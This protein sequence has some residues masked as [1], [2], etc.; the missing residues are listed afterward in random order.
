MKNV[1]LG[2]VVMVLCSG[3]AAWLPAGSLL[4]AQKKAA[5]GIRVSVDSRVELMSIIFRL[6]GNREYGQGK[7]PSYTQDVESHFGRFRD[8]AVVK[9]ATKL[10]QTRGVSYDAVMGMAVHVT[11]ALTLQEKVP[12]SPQPETLDPRWT[13]ESAREFLTLARQFVADTQFQDFFDKHEPLYRVAVQ[14]MQEVLDKHAHLDWFDRFFGP[15]QGADFHVVLGMLNGGSSY[16]ARVTGADGQEELYSVIGVWM[17]DSGGQPTFAPA[18]ASTVVHEFTHSYTNPLVDQFATQLQGP[19]EKLYGLVKKEM[20]GQAYGN[21]KTLMYESL[22]RAC[23][24]RYALA[25]G[26]PAAM[27]RAAAYESSRSFYWVGELADV[28]GEYD[29]QP[30]KYKDLAEFFPRITAFFE[31]YARNADAKIGAIKGKNQEQ[32]QQWRDKGPK[33]VSMVPANGAENVDPSLKAIVVTFDRPM[34]D[35]CWSVVTLGSQDEFPKGAGPVHYDAAR[36]VFTMP[37]A[38]QP[39]KEYHFGLNSE[40]FHAFQSEEGIPLAPVEVRFKTR[41]ADKK[42]GQVQEGQDE[43]PKVVSIVP[44]NG[45]EDVDPGL[46]AIVVTF[47]RP[48]RD[49]CWSVVIVGSQDE[50]PKIAGP[51]RYD[52]ARKVLTMPVTLQP[53]KEYRFGLNSERFHA[54]QSEQGIPL[55]PVEVR[56]KTRQVDK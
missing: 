38:L 13:P 10:R 51:L 4:A 48:M 31:E 24:L 2:S 12:F 27:N 35:K 32:V 53:D 50:F 14:R 37:V 21:W 55:A 25:T 20:A 40:R 8:H 15:R 17:V 42:E 41:P 36:K 26:G 16:G 6:A 7:V 44:A 3:S 46:N 18:I 19:G 29:T 43:A 45:A 28:L 47:D 9:L 33:I 39:D 23:G 54:F 52:A 5:T 22:N 34:R 1:V 30:R 56:F 49:K 11:G